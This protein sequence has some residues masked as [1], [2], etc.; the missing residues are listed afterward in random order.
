MKGNLVSL[1]AKQAL[2]VW[3]LL[4]CWMTRIDYTWSGL[5]DK[6]REKLVEQDEI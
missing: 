5:W 1:E 6:E 3:P 4:S 2:T